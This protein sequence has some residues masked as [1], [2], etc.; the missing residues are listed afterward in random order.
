MSTSTGLIIRVAAALV[1][2]LVVGYGAWG[3]APRRAAAPRELRRLVAAAVL[4]YA[5]GVVAVLAR[6]PVPAVAAFAGGVA[7]AS[8][9]AWLSRGNRPDEGDDNDGGGGGRP[10][11]DRTPPRD[12]GPQVQP[13][14]DWAR[15][16]RERRQWERGPDRLP[17]PAARD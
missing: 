8:L 1:L 6:R 4:L 2:V 5:V 11:V 16:D 13:E 17:A 7:A 15:F 14:L 3:R 10:P 12:S 9:A